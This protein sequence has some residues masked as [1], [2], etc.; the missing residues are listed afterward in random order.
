M[1]NCVGIAFVDGWHG[2][3]DGRQKRMRIKWICQRNSF[4]RWL[5]GCSVGLVDKLFGNEQKM[6]L[7]RRDGISGMIKRFAVP[8]CQW[9]RNWIKWRKMRFSDIHL[10]FFFFLVAL[11]TH[12]HTYFARLSNIGYTESLRAFCCRENVPKMLQSL[13][14]LSIPAKQ[15]TT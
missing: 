4:V 12:T 6:K 13:S 8:L 7:Y 2:G 3:W 9:Q 11:Q 5:V 15:K 1:E 14:S 10:L